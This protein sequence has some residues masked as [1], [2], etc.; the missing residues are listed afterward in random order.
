MHVHAE[1]TVCLM[2]CKQLI[3]LNLK[4]LMSCNNL[5]IVIQSVAHFTHLGEELIKIRYA[6]AQLAT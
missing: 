1:R 3:Q 6:L 4:F 2:K 5:L